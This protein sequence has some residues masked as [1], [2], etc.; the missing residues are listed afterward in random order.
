[1]M[2]PEKLRR[3]KTL[4]A[5]FLVL[6]MMMSLVSCKTGHSDTVVKIVCPELKKYPPA[7]LLKAL[8]EFKALP[9]DSAIRILVGD[10]S[11]LRDQIRVCAVSK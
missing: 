9:K 4:C 7:V 10:Y 2:L 3:R 8:D 1:M 6:P 5:M 11:H